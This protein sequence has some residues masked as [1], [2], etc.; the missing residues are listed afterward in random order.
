MGGTC[1][2]AIGTMPD[3]FSITF[4]TM[5]DNVCT[6][7]ENFNK[8]WILCQDPGDP[9]TYIGDPIILCGGPWAG[10]NITM[11]FTSSVP[12]S[13]GQPGI[14]LNVVG[15]YR[16]LGTLT[17]NQTHTLSFY[18][19]PSMECNWQATVDA[20]PVSGSSCGGDPHFIGFDG[21]E[22]TVHGTPGSFHN[23]F[24]DKNIIMNA[25]FEDYKHCPG[26]TYVNKI[27]LK[28]GT[29]ES[30][31]TYIQFDNNGKLIINDCETLYGKKVFFATG[32]Y[33]TVGTAVISRNKKY[34]KFRKPFILGEFLDAAIVDTGIYR[35]II[36]R[37]RDTIATHL[38][39]FSFCN[40]GKTHNPN[41]II[42]STLLSNYNVNDNFQ[43]EN[44]FK[45]K[46]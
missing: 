41:G 37:F 42:G 27:G 43:V 14:W 7:C 25:Q 44:L 3:A 33:P 46:L 19:S 13:G 4:T 6:D 23:L 28:V 16:L 32:N 35:F 26:T 11:T 20:I 24:S 15:Y 22:F 39:V 34:E 2:N 9:C 40:S 5:A 17:A 29:I 38:N 18:Y 36:C 45:G 10:M 8:E 1:A 30:G 12:V 21:K 31:F